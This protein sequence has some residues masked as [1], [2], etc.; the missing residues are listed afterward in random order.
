MSENTSEI[1]GTSIKHNLPLAEDF[2]GESMGDTPGGNLLDDSEH[3]NLCLKD[4]IGVHTHYR[5]QWCWGCYKHCFS[6]L[7]Y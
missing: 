6:T 4:S 3:K 1:A 7:V 2:P 5:N